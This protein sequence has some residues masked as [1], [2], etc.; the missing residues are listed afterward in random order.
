MTGHP[1]KGGEHSIILYPPCNDL[2]PY[3]LLRF[4]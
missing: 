1:P 4:A 2:F 3:H